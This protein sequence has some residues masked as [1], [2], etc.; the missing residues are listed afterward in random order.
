MQYDPIKFKLGKVFNRAPWMRKLFY[1]LLDVLLLRSWHIRRAKREWMNEFGKKAATILDAGSGFGQY[2][3]SW[4]KQDDV[5][6][7]D[8]KAEQIEDCN[9]FA[10][11]IGR[12]DKVRFE[13][14]D[15][16]QYV[17][18]DTYDIILSVD[19]MEHIEED[20]KVFGNFYK[21]L[22]KGGMLLISTPSDKGGSDAHDDHEGGEPGVHGFIDEH[23]RDGYSIDDI[24]EKLRRAGFEEVQTRYSYGTWG[25]ISWV[26][27]MKWP[28]MMLNSSAVFYF[29]LPIYYLIVMPFCLIMNQVDVSSLQKEGT[30]LIVKAWK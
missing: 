15:L 27:S 22:H 19:V 29:I 1:F 5:T 14:G 12:E 24:A 30:G 4:R 28:I 8:V 18:E 6:G 21:S 3:F 25:H 26:L 7:V 11:K 20:E 10:Q 13:E 2:T 9:G 16:T 17:K 23:V